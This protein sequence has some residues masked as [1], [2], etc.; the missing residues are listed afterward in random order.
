LRPVASIRAGSDFTKVIDLNPGNARQYSYRGNI[1]R[2]FGLR[3]L[4]IA[5]FRRALELDP[6]DEQSRRVL[7]SLGA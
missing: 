2:Q 4:A 6:T 7:E 5:D 3:E 1:Y